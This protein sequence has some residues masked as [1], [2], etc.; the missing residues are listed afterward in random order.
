M[1]ITLI[2]CASYRIRY[3]PCMY[4]MQADMVDWLMTPVASKRPS[5]QEVADSERLRILKDSYAR[6]EIKLVPKL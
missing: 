4:L 5:S 2:F 1:Q 6:A 3:G